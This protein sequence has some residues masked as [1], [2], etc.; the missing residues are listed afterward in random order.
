M[1]KKRPRARVGLLVLALSVL[2]R[3]V[4]SVDQVEDAAWTFILSAAVRAAA[5]EAASAQPRPQSPQQFCRTALASL[6]TGL[7]DADARGRIE[8]LARGS[9]V[10]HHLAFVPDMS[11]CAV[12]LW[13]VRAA[14]TLAGERARQSSPS[15]SELGVPADAFALDAEGAAAAAADTLFEGDARAQILGALD[16]AWLGHAVAHRAV[17]S[18]RPR[19]DLFVMAACPYAQEVQAALTESVLPALG[20]TLDVLVHPIFFPR[21]LNAS[22]QPP[23]LRP[24]SLCASAGSDLLDPFKLGRV[25]C[26]MHGQEEVDEGLR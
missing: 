25:P 26:S 17:R 3:A 12:L 5:D 13:Y 20:D 14:A 8:A 6:R 16:R 10:R 11:E 23:A 9:V 19:L 4:P 15:A 18:A 2:A 22:R 7:P 1:Q 21:A 24:A